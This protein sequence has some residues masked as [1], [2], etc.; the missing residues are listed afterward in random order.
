MSSNTI[1]IIGIDI[2]PKDDNMYYILVDMSYMIFYRFH[3]LCR[4]WKFA[5]PE[6][7]LPDKLD[8]CEEFIN[9]YI[10]IFSKMKDT[11]VKKLHMQK[12]KN[13]K[14]IC[15]KD[16]PRKNIW[17][18][19]L[20]K[21]Y[22][23]NR[24]KD[25]SFMVGKFFEIIYSNGFL[26][27]IGFDVLLESESLEADDVIAITKNII[28]KKYPLNG[29]INAHIIIIANDHDYL[30][31]I[32]TK[33]YLINLAFKNISQDNKIYKSAEDNLL[34]KILIGDKS[35]C[36]PP[37]FSKL[38]K[39]KLEEYLENETKLQD[40]LIKYDLMDNFNLNSLIIDFRNIPNELV[41]YFI[42]K[43][44]TLFRSI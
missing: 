31:L 22:K 21:R 36:I 7:P 18:N 37:V 40:D 44:A 38:T 41:E 9:K 23:Q 30:Q 5:K 29:T 24:D 10:S 14:F 27:S 8:E 32:D 42:E 4:W 25:D 13:Y 15:A 1:N 19:S 33:T 39:K 2:T 20:F 34:S 26:N 28:R 16:C 12:I 11:I 35:D 17:R 3:A 6:T 43:N